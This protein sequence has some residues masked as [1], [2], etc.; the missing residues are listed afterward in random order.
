VSPARCPF[1]RGAAK[2]AVRRPVRCT[3][4]RAEVANLRENGQLLRPVGDPQQRPVRGALQHRTEHGVRRGRV[5]VPGG[6]VEK[7]DGAVGEHG[8]GHTEALQLPARDRLAPG[9]EHGIE[10]VF[11][12]VQPRA[13][14]E[15]AQEV[16]YLPVRVV[17][18]TVLARSRLVAAVL[19]G[20][21]GR[22]RV[23]LS[24]RAS[25]V[26]VRAADGQPIWLST[27]GEVAAGSGFVH[28]KHPHAL[29]VYR[30]A[31]D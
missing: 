26:D 28:G 30:K 3:G 9:R 25:S 17:E 14:P 2:S 5:E 22:S 29:V 31:G 1:Q 19:T 6:F 10:T 21:L 12:P 23:Y 8:P 15:P 16:R 4:V 27:D 11:Q 20:T 18:A 13:E 24:W 7:E